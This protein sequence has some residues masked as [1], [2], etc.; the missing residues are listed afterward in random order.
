MSAPRRRVRT[1]VV[2]V[3]VVAVAATAGCVPGSGDEVATASMQ[4]GPRPAGELDREPGPDDELAPGGPSDPGDP[5]LPDLGLP[6]LEM[7]DLGVPDVPDGL[8]EDCVELTFAYTELVALALAGDPNDE[9]DG[10]VD[11]LLEQA[12]EDLHADIEV[13]RATVTEAAGAGLFDAGRALLSDEFI[14]ANERITEW[15]ST[16]C[17]VAEGS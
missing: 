8:S 7:P 4:S 14:A 6:D 16:R 11:Q 13:V 3:L 10:L 2:A 9:I 1:V 5:E 12:P 17:T 15:L